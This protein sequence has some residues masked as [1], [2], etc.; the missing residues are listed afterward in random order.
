MVFGQQLNHRRTS[1]YNMNQS[2]SNHGNTSSDLC[3]LTS[4]KSVW[5]WLSLRA[6]EASKN[7]GENFPLKG[8]NHPHP[9]PHLHTDPWPLTSTAEAVDSQAASSCWFMESGSWWQGAPKSTVSAVSRGPAG[10]A[11]ASGL[12]MGPFNRSTP[13]LCRP[14]K[15]NPTNVQS[16]PQ[17]PHPVTLIQCVTFICISS[18]GSRQLHII[19]RPLWLCLIDQWYLCCLHP[20]CMRDEDLLCKINRKKI[21]CCQG[22]HTCLLGSVWFASHFS[23]HLHAGS[24]G[25]F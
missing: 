24:T 10:N 11:Q 6:R 3:G 12:S 8:H 15:Q 2:V 17:T 7:I 19:K 25:S 21:S 18:I 4:H 16:T 9:P 14:G 20:T 1:L 13:G 23:S 5:R 22:K